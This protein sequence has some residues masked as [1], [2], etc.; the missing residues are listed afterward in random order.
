M[1][2]I[3][4]VL[5]V[6]ALVGCEDDII[7]PDN[8]IYEDNAL[9][10]ELRAKARDSF[11]ADGNSFKMEA[12][13]WRD[14]MPGTLPKSSGLISVNLL[15]SD[16]SSPIPDKL[17]MVKQYVIFDHSVWITDYE[18]PSGHS[19]NDSQ[20]ERIS[21]NGPAWEPEVYVDVIS[22]IRDNEANKNYYLIDRS[23]QINKVE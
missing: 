15:K 7:I 12:S 23:V 16:H 11:V 1:K 4:F 20:R 22:M 19:D 13:V 2:R 17:E 21:R 9:A 8:G 10:T 18:E 6:F 5:L 14:F 3:I